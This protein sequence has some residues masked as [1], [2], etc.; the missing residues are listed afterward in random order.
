MRLAAC[1]AVTITACCRTRGTNFA[2]RL[3]LQPLTG[4]CTRQHPTTSHTTCFPPCP[5]TMPRRPCKQWRA[6]W[7]APGVGAQRDC[8]G[9]RVGA[10]VLLGVWV[11]T[12]SWF[13]FR[14]DRGHH[15]IFIEMM[16]ARWASTTLHCSTRMSCTTRAAARCCSTLEQTQWHVANEWPPPMAKYYYQ[17]IIPSRCSPPAERAK[18]DPP[19][20]LYK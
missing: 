17:P 9:C 11:V 7:V 18:L 2:S 6:C 14:F 19:R 10:E 20:S 16:R 15:K 13:C 8:G 3:L 4:C 5:I 1:H 12:C